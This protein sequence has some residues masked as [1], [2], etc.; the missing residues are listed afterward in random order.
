MHLSK[1]KKRKCVSFEVK[2]K[3]REVHFSY[4]KQISLCTHFGKLEKIGAFVRIN[5]IF[6]FL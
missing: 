6:V 1:N 3:V 2:I 4:F 5:S